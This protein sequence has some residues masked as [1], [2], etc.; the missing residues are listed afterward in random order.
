MNRRDLIKGAA[1]SSLFLS[2]V[3]LGKSKKFQKK[4]T[5]AE[6][7][8]LPVWDE[9]KILFDEKALEKEYLFTFGYPKDRCVDTLI[10]IGQG[11]AMIYSPS[12]IEGVFFELKF[13]KIVEK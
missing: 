5:V 6:L 11:L 4:M 12:L 9:K 1:V 2:D 13:V 10:E 8:A 7:K 3:S